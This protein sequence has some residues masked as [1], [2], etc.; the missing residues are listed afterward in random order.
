MRT[1]DGES[2]FCEVFLDDAR[3]PVTDRVG[4]ENDGWRVTNVTLR[5]ER[6]TAF[7][8][9]IITLR[10][11]IR[12]LVELA[13]AT[14]V[15]GQTA[16]DDVA[17]R[18]HVGRLQANVDGLWRMTQMG[19]AEAERTGVPAPTG[20]A[21]KLRYSE[22]A[23]EIGDLAL[24]TIGRP[25]LA[26]IDG[27]GTR[28]GTRLL[29]VA[30]IHDCGRYVPNPTE[31]HRRTRP[32]HAAVLTPARK[33]DSRRAGTPFAIYIGARRKPVDRCA[34]RPHKRG[35]RAMSKTVAR[36]LGVLMALALV[37]AA[38]GGDDDDSSSGGTTATTAEKID[39]TAIG[40]WDDGPC[41]AAKPP[42]TDRAD[43]RLRVARALAE[44]PGGRAGSVRDRV[45]RTRRR[46]RFVHQ[47][48]D[49]RR[50]RQRRPGRGVCADDR[51]C[52]RRGD[53]ERPGNGRPGR[54]VRGN[55]H[56][57]DPSHRFE[58]HPGRLGR[59][60]RLSAR[61]IRYR[62]HLPA[63]RRPSSTRTSTRSASSAS[64]SRRPPR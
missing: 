24:R 54:R 47:G 1:I 58:R 53:G 46:E 12:T 35:N 18:K 11:Q 43:D 45:Q 15:D 55:G 62:R 28:H 27:P 57:E 51:R 30:P 21:V 52:G 31:P 26:G 39:Y 59:P 14:P 56:G 60:E 6:G 41:D 61:R 22:L 16:W 48:H 23:Q 38:C 10:S 5:F 37:A 13:L 49:L 4:A 25:A 64:T 19:I 36:T 8:Q 42:L 40:L 33:S 17:L 44:G 20:S 63:A 50:R 29:L 7:A 32:R 34:P 9:H 2:H 3:V